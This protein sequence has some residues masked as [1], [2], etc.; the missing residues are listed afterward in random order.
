[1]SDSDSEKIPTYYEFNR[2]KLL[3]QK[4]NWY[5]KNLEKARAQKRNWYHK[6]KNNEEFKQKQK[7]YYKTGYF[8]NKLLQKFEIM[9]D[10]IQ[11]G[12]D[13]ELLLEEFSS[14]IDQL[15]KYDLINEDDYENIKDSLNS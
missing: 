11:I 8:K 1:M 14:I 10:E 15:Y 12:N 9:K 7:E 4:K 6:N 3:K 13:S 2:E 5:Q